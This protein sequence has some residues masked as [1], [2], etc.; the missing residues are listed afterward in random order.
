MGANLYLCSPNND[1]NT[2][3]TAFAPATVANLSCGF[4]VLG[5]A[6]DQ[7]GDR[8]S[9]TWNDVG[10]VRIASISGD[11]GKLPLHAPDNTAGAAVIALLQALGKT[12][13]GID[14][15]I[16]KQMPLGSGLGSSAASA[17]A[18]VV[19]ANHLLGSPCS[20]L[21]LLPY[22]LAGEAVASG[23]A[24][25]DN[26]FPSLLGGIVLIRSYQPLEVVQLPVLQGLHVVVLHPDVEIMTKDARNIL[27]QQIPMSDGIRQTAN[28]AGLVA[29]LYSNNLHLI[30]NSL[31]D[32]FAEPYR[33][34]LIPHFT[35]LKQVALYGGAIGF[36]ISGSGP[37]MFALCDSAVRA[38]QVAELL[39]KTLTQKKVVFE[40]YASKINIKGATIV[41]Q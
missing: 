38:Q 24:H 9:A 13:Q 4:D 31:H 16:Q 14:L 11:K 29:G 5:L 17:V 10:A 28:L 22:V 12:Q 8:V 35:Q 23:T 30:G 39:Q 27:P 19:A 25:G 26:V 6:I 37:S 40:L 36:G 7:P 20:K 41:A 15:H 21:G 32:V 2:M 18:A 1:L 34:P 3:I 33:A